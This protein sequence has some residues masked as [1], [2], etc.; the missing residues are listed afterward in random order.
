MNAEEKRQPVGLIACS[1]YQ[2]AHVEKALRQLL[3]DIDGLSFVK[4]GMTI[5]LKTNLVT[6]SAPDKAVVTH[7]VLLAALTKILTEK[8]ARVVIGDSPGGLFTQGALEYAYRASELKIAEEAGA[9][10]NKNV[11]VQEISYPE[12]K[13]LKSFTC[14]AWLLEV[15]AIIDCCKLKTHGMMALSANVKN[16]FG[17]IPGTMKPEYHFRFPGHEDFADMLIDLNEYLKPSLYLTD[18]IVGMEGNGPTSGKPRKIGAILA[19]KNPYDLDI[20]CAGIIGLKAKEVPTIAAA[21]RRGLCQTDIDQ[22]LLTGDPGQFFVPD[23][24]LVRKLA[25]IEFSSHLP[26]FIMPLARSILTAGPRV[27]KTECIG[28]R[29]CASICP[30]KAITMVKKKPVIDKKACIRCFCCQEFC[31]VGAMKVHR[32]PVARVLSRG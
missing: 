32:S 2:M 28:C 17:A 19:G 9:C 3:L 23:Y 8:G 13:V 29:K 12:A 6:G 22:M 18:A 7:P 4:E 21:I 31:P 27:K 24:K 1:D 5:G 10:L 11:A 15:D 20:V 25:D 30:A 26:A 16:M 14:S